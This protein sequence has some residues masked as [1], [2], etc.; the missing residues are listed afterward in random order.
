MAS[1]WFEYASASLGISFRVV[2]DFRSEILT[3]KTY[4]HRTLESFSL[5]LESVLQGLVEA[6][7][8]LP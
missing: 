6:T 1:F 2:R 4:L 3:R 8:G 7:K 5:H